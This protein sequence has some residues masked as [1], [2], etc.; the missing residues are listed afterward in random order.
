MARRPAATDVLLALVLGLEMQVELL[1]VDAPGSDVE[2]GP[3]AGGG[4]EVAA[5]LPLERHA[6]SAS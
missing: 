6:L 3:R 2:S 4:W 1:F 5:R